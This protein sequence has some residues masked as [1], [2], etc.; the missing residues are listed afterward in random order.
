MSEPSLISVLQAHATAIGPVMPV[1]LNGGAVCRLDLTAANP[2]LAKADLRDTS[3]FAALVDT[4]LQ[5]QGAAI[6]VGGYLED[7]IIYRR[8]EHFD[9][10]A[11]K[12]SVHLGVDLWLPA[13]TPVLAP[14]PAR[15]HSFQDND[16]FGDYGPTIILEHEL[17]GH[18]FYTLYGHLSRC[19]LAHL[20]VG[21]VMARGEAFARVGPYPENG[22]WPPHLHLQLMT[23]LLGLR[24]DFPGVCTPSQQNKFARICLNPNLI[25][26]S[27]VLGY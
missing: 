22:D 12:R 5:Q 10:A 19:S 6:G 18:L 23:D 13:H 7:R 11:D 4:L 25:L 17:A 21:Q 3:A 15:V 24:G 16:H 14:L 26:K 9:A 2:L 1:D 20:T 8:S 27:R